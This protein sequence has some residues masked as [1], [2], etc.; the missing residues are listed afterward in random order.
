MMRLTAHVLLA[1]ALIWLPAAVRAQV[2]PNG[3]A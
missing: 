2:F 3:S 1:S